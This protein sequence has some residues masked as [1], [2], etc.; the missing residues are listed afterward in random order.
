MMTHISVDRAKLKARFL[1]YIHQNTMSQIDTKC[2][3]STDGQ[4][5]FAHR[6]AA[7]LQ[8]MGISVEVSQA[9]VVYAMVPA[10]QPDRPAIGFVAHMDTPPG[11]RCE[12][13]HPI[14][15]ENYDGGT[16][17]V[18]KDLG[19]SL[20]PEEYGFLSGLVG[21]ELMLSDGTSI[22]G[23]DDKAGVAEVVTL[24]ELLASHPDLPHGDVYGAFTV[25]EEIG[26][27]I[28]YF[29]LDK[30]PCDFAYTVDTDGNDLRCLDYETICDGRV[31]VRVTGKPMH[32]GIGT[33][34]IRNA[35]ALAMEFHSMLP[36]ELDPFVAKD[37][38]GFDHLQEFVGQVDAA[39]LRYRVANFEE[40]ELWTQMRLFQHI[41]E[42]LN[43]KYGYAAFQV[44]MRQTAANMKQYI[45]KDLRC[46]E[47]AVRA[48]EAAGIAV[49]HAG[50]RG[51]TDGALLS[52]RGLLAPNINTGAYNALSYFELVSVD[53]M[54]KCVEILLR[55]VS[56]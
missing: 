46:I 23:A 27:G 49:R 48:I 51:G 8:A 37:R 44:T 22:L 17:T 29:E 12:E 56:R 28:E 50:I 4:V 16:I 54:C 14:Y 15:I 41:A 11:F 1:S 39:T 43:E 21:H 53:D 13:I 18:N 7:E 34:V 9:G 33:G 26:K 31:D 45:M 40:T 2:I 25:D 47:Y 20:S 10:N 36:A 3:P 6:L 55:I 35:C 32:P 24:L 38:D 19:F 42:V 5:A 52:K 30:F